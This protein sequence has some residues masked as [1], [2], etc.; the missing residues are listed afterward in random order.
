MPC[1]VGAV[2]ATT[3]AS[4]DA[5]DFGIA[6]QEEHADCGAGLLRADIGSFKQ[7]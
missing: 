3:V 1:L 7:H 5:R 2:S 6:S 4:C